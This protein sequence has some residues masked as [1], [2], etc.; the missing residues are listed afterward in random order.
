M[1]RLLFLIGLFLSLSIASAQV[2]LEKLRA[3]PEDATSL[4]HPYVAAPDTDTPAP[5]GY[6]PF[7]ISH[8][9]RHGSR[10]E[11]GESLITEAPKQLDKIRREGLLTE[12]GK[13]L[14]DFLQ[15]VADQSQGRWGELTDI[16]EQEHR[17]IAFRMYKRFT[18][19]FSDK[20]RQTIRCMA[21]TATRTIVSMA[22]SVSELRSLSPDIRPDFEVGERYNVIMRLGSGFPDQVARTTSSYRKKRIREVD[23]MN[24]GTILFTD[25]SAALSRIPNKELFFESLYRGWAIHYAMGLPPFDLRNYLDEDSFMKIWGGIDGRYYTNF[26]YPAAEEL[27]LD[28]VNHADN[29]IEGGSVCADL[30]YGHDVMLMRLMSRMGF[31]KGKINVEEAN[32]IGDCASSVPMAS[33]LQIAF[34]R[35]RKGDVLV[36]FLYNEQER[37]LPG[38]KPAEGPYYRWNDVKAFWTKP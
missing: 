20:S 27:L 18:P 24:C 17:D 11:T 21:S 1:K 7:Y 33:N 16:G 3:N 15:S 14:A 2:T 32:S 13:E 8:Y 35:N 19:V 22:S 12:K 31:G 36:K 5:T 37:T 23:P 25:P 28:I 26:N 9:G 4:F 29:A 10:Y 6:K 30:R 38:L 34:Y